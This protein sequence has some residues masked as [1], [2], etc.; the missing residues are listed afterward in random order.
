MGF[1]HR[2]VW[3]DLKPAEV[4]ER[5]EAVRAYH[6]FNPGKPHAVLSIVALPPGVDAEVHKTGFNIN[7]GYLPPNY[8]REDRSVS[9]AAAA[10]SSRNLGGTF[11]AFDPPLRQRSLLPERLKLEEIFF[12][13]DSIADHFRDGRTLT[14]TKSELQRGLKTPTQI[15]TVTVV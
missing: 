3:R 9:P 11:T 14:E 12:T 6:R 1:Y 13:Q 5:V 8:L 2:V 10:A 4:M 7:I 15:E